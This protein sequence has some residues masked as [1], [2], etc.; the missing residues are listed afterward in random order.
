MA[1]V[2]YVHEERKTMLV[3]FGR[4]SYS[5]GMGYGEKW[6]RGKWPKKI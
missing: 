2:T 1:A 4:M 3:S 6:A 5:A